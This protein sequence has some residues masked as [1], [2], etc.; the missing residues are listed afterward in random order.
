MQPGI[1]VKLGAYRSTC[2]VQKTRAIETGFVSAI[3]IG[4]E[5]RN[6]KVEPDTD[7]QYRSSG[8]PGYEFSLLLQPASVAKQVLRNGGGWSEAR[9]HLFRLPPR[10]PAA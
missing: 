1:Q 9:K 5:P 3:W 6:H 7:N 8:L 10:K 4:A 2:A